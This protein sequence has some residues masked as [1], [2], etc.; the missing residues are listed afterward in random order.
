MLRSQEHL[1]TPLGLISTFSAAKR[2]PLILKGCKETV[3][4]G[5]RAL[6]DP[7]AMQTSS[8]AL[9]FTGMPIVTPGSDFGA[10]ENLC[11]LLLQA[12]ELGHPCQLQLRGWLC[13]G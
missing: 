2:I 12:A 1:I 4:L 6:K 3:W 10:K 9:M 11:P 13:H 7:E 8:A 5:L